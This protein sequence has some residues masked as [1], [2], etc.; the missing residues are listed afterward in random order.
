MRRREALGVLLAGSGAAALAAR[1]AESAPL[2][3]PVQQR[4]RADAIVAVGGFAGDRMRRN[5]SARLL[6]FDI[7]PYVRLVEEHNYTDWNW[8]GEQPGKWL[9]AAILASSTFREAKLH[10]AAGMIFGR[11]LA[12]QQADGYLG[13]TDTELRTPAHPVRG[14]DPYELYFTLHALVTAHE[15]WYEAR[16]IPA[17]RRLADYLI[18]YIGPG[19][20]EFWARPK[21]TSIS[22]HAIH[23]GFE[24]TLLIDPVMRLHLATGDAKYRTWC[25]WVVSNMDKWS[26]T[27]FYTNLDKVASGEMGINQLLPK[28]HAHTFQMNAQGL[29]RLYQATGDSSYLAKVRGAWR[30]IASKRTY[31]TGG[32]G[33][34]EYYEAD[35]E[36][37][38]GDEGVETCSVLSWLQLSQALLEITGDPAYADCMERTLWNHAFA[39][40]TWEADGY[41]YGVP[42]TGW[43][44]TM[45]F[46]GPNCC[47]SNGPRMFAMLPTWIYSRGAAGLY[48]NQFIDSRA[49]IEEGPGEMLE[50]VQ[51]T[52]YPAGEKI[53]LEI[54]PAAPRRHAIH[55]RIPA[56]CAT[57]MLRVNGS[58]QADVRPGGYARLERTW[59]R[60]D[61][62]ELSL[63][64]EPKWIQGEHGNTGFWA[65]MRGPVVYVIDGVWQN[66]EMQRRLAAGPGVPVLK[67]QGGGMPARPVALDPAGPGLAPFYQ[68]PGRLY[69]GTEALFAM[70]PFGD[71]GRWYADPA[72]RPSVKDKLYPYAVWIPAY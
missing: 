59:N 10:D 71:L 13:I 3:Q 2:S 9:E 4:L 26:T 42:L 27:N 21:D 30:D 15:E 34:K 36:L 18:R 35:Y 12:A 58:V 70:T 16:A 40:Q 32:A 66:A 29:L 39:S 22:G 41:R 11:L 52:N 56:W 53:E 51:R 19:K 47:S 14:M 60:G 43:K 20:A 54:T 37:S 33:N 46:T 6:V 5:I 55:I 64:M 44:P 25:E 31:I 38:N 23:H 28:T 48:V 8:I 7:N 69:D 1:P 45:Y 49:R 65:L 72:A 68:V 67:M 50:I 57:P 61:R 62:I 63:P 17:A 24:G